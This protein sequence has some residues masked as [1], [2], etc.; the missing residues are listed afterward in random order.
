LPENLVEKPADAGRLA[1]LFRSW[2]FNG[3]LQALEKPAEQQSVLI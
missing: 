1:G 3:M 2:G